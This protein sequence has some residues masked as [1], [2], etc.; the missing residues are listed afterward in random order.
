MPEGAA[1]STEQLGN[2]YKI[3]YH[4][5]ASR[6]VLFKEGRPNTGE[7][8]AEKIA[9]ELAALIGV[10]HAHYEFARYGE[11]AGVVTESVVEAGARLVHGNELLASSVGSYPD[12]EAKEFRRREHTLR[13]VVAYLKASSDKLGPPSGFAH[14]NQIITG[15]DVFVGY[16]ML[17]AWIANQDR[18]DQNWGLVRTASGNSF[19]A[20]TF[21]H[22]SSMGR[23]E[24]DVRRQL[25]LTTRDKNQQ[26]EAYV[27][28]AKSAFYTSTA[29]GMKPLGTVDAFFFG[30]S[31]AEG[32]GA[33]WKQRLGD[34]SATAVEDI[35]ARVPAALMTDVARQFT[36]RLLAANRT[37]ILNI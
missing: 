22:G 6:H 35:V 27:G 31:Q 25:I 1:E 29:A 34:I 28:R 37:R 21:D 5:S 11:R 16:L 26:M 4:D 24:S 12:A 23:N 36:I 10:P 15:L 13:R 20:A 17:D 18:H 30:A 14:T 8:W 2:K 3:W 19:L 33:E 9:C 32:A 7:N